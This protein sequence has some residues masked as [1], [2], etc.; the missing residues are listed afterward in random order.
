M[1]RK[2]D[3]KHGFRYGLVAAGLCSA[4]AAVINAIHS[5]TGARIRDF[6]ATPDKLLGGLEA[7]DA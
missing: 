6:P 5:A 7:L 3:P 2:S 1:V 4:G